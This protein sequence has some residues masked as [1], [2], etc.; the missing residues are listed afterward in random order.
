MLKCRVL[1]AVTSVA[2]RATDSM[3]V[4]ILDDTGHMS[5]WAAVEVHTAVTVEVE[6]A[7]ARLVR[8]LRDVVANVQDDAVVARH[9][10]STETASLATASSRCPRAT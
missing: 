7:E 5:I 1:I 10:R 8:R 3:V 9:L 4:Q 2:C 6:D